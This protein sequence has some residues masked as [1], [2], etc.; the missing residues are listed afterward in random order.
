MRRK[1]TKMLKSLN[2][3]LD[4]KEKVLFGKNQITTGKNAWSGKKVLSRPMRRKKVMRSSNGS[5]QLT[6][7]HQHN[8][9]GKLSGMTKR[10]GTK[11]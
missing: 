11:E 4:G 8:G 10:S 7:R 2:G 3:T 1:F 5:S 9:V 6:G